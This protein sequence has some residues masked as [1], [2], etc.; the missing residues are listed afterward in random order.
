MIDREAGSASVLPASFVSK[1]RDDRGV[2]YILWSEQ[3]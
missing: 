3:R 1:G 2:L